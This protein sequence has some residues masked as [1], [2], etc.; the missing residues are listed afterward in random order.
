MFETVDNLLTKK[1]L[2]ERPHFGSSAHD[3]YA[4]AGR[5][6]RQLDVNLHMVREREANYQKLLPD[7][8]AMDDDQAL[9]F[10]R[11]IDEMQILAEAFYYSAWRA[12]AALRHLP[13]LKNLDC[14]PIRTVRNQ[15]LEH[16]EAKNSGITHQGFLFGATDG[17]A[18]KPP[19]RGPQPHNDAG[20]YANAEALRTTLEAA[21]TRTAS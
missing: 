1:L 9:A 14:V 4:E 13:G 17:P 10:H 20:M 3:A 8:V 21:L 11:L 15:L 5:R 16:P 7:M 6:L 18:L 19:V 2:A 12:I